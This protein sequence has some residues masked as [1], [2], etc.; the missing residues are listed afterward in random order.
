MKRVETP[1]YDDQISAWLVEER[2]GVNGGW[3]EHNVMDV[4][5]EPGEV[6]VH[7]F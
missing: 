1:A 2:F 5:D 4:E 3:L 6:L 7:S